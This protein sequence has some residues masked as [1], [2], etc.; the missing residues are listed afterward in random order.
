VLVLTAKPMADESPEVRFTLTQEVFI[1]ADIYSI[2][3]FSTTGT[4]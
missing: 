2:P 3:D 4:N 1:Q